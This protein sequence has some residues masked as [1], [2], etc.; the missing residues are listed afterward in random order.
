MLARPF[1]DDN[2]KRLPLLTLHYAVHTHTF[3]CT[4]NV[5]ELAPSVPNTKGS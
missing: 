4:E 3:P 5:G 2:T 1:G